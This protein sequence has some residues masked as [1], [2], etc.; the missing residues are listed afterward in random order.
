MNAVAWGAARLFHAGAARGSDLHPQGLP[1][2]GGKIIA[3]Y[4]VMRSSTEKFGAIVTALCLATCCVWCPVQHSAMILVQI[5]T[6]GEMAMHLT[7]TV[8]THAYS[9]GKV[10]PPYSSHLAPL[11]HLDTICSLRGLFMPCRDCLLLPPLSCR[12]KLVHSYPV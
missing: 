8:P 12:L 1:A 11:P 4:V 3:Y 5:T 7:L 9:W 10:Q 6:P 2:C